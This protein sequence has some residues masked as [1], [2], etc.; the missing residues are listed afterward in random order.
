MLK[1]IL[2]CQMKGQT[3]AGV[4]VSHGSGL[5]ALMAGMGPACACSGMAGDHKRELGQVGRGI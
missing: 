3:V 1:I 4:G 5:T 2:G